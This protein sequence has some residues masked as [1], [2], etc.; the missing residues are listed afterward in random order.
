MDGQVSSFKFQVKGFTLVETIVHITIFGIAIIGIT[1]FIATIYRSQSYSLQ[2][3]TAINE[4]RR[5]IETMVKEIREAR[6][7]DDGSYIIEKA[8]NNEFIFYSD[9]DKDNSVER[10]RYFLG[11][12]S[13]GSLSD[14]C[15]TF[16]DG[17][18]C[19]VTFADFFT[20][21]LE[22]AEVTVSVEGDFGSG[23]EDAEIFADGNS[24]G[25]VCRSGCN[26]CAG[27]W[28]GS[29]VYDVTTQAQDNNIQ[30]VADSSWRVNDFCDWEEINH[31]MKAKFDF[32]WTE[33]LA[34]GQ[35]DFQ[36]GVIE[37]S[38]WP[39]SYPSENEQ[40]TVLSRYVRNATSSVFTYFDQNGNE[41]TSTPARPEET[42]LMRVYLKINEDMNRSPRDFELESDV[43]IRNLKTNL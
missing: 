14:D 37:P 19:S 13:S 30:L 4:A 24:L 17:G 35:T 33:S 21:T 32:S 39:I 40:V 10:V 2:Q 34:S 5:G 38:G 11:G 23:N 18:S 31:A 1:A 9:I 29:A 22:S 6:T 27:F 8:D 26:D 3:S 16:L 41:I 43:Q 7:G 12:N 25:D 42:T 15:V 20:D 28:Q 36:K